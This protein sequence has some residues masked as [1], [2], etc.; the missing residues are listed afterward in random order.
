MQRNSR[1]RIGDIL[2]AAGAISEE[3]LK[4]GLEHAK[5]KGIQVGKAVTQLG[6][7]TQEEI[8]H[9]LSE[10]LD[11]PSIHLQTYHIDPAVKTLFEEKYARDK[12]ILPLFKI[13][14][15][16][17]VSM[18]D[19]LDVFT[20]DELSQ[21]T[22]L[23]I[24]PAVSTEEDIN[25]AMDMLYGSTGKI[26]EVVKSIEEAEGDKGISFEDQDILS[27]DTSVDEAPVIRLVNMIFTQAIREKAS[28]IHI[29]PEEDILRVRLRID[30]VLREL[31]TQPK[32]LQYAIISRIKIMAEL[33]IAERRLP[34]DGRF[35]LRVDN[36][37]VDIRVSTIPTVNGENIVMRILDKTNLIVRVEDLGFTQSAHEKFENAL[38][39]PNGIILVTGPTGSGK[40][41]TLYSAMHAINSLEKNMITIE[42]P[43]EYRLKI[44]R[45]SQVSTKIGMTFAMGLRA[46]LR[47]DPDI[48]MVGEIRDSETATVAVQAALTGHLVLSTLHTNDAPGAVTRLIDMGVEPFLVSSSLICIVA[49]RLVRRICNKCKTTYAAS[50]ALIKELHLTPGKE[51]QFSKGRGCRNCKETGYRGRIA[52][53]EVLNVDDTI[54][55]MIIERASLV[56]VRKAAVKNGMKTL[57]Q[58]GLLKAL[59][60]LTT[61]EEVVH[62]T[63]ESE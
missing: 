43:I 39:S 51:Y 58:D 29:E 12:K 57:R 18:V 59:K 6:F 61:V 50:D 7:T 35:Q 31:V 27:A 46:I 11:I 8:M 55:D 47:Q 5:D 10:Q 48:I 40:T 63:R 16:L 24:E 3:Q 62:T 25:A 21:K 56:Q 4:K 2:L 33:N 28:D 13:N 32:K 30:G 23:E 19:P 36:H 17:T 49:Q 15:S 38:D 42:D 52:I 44:I 14:N 45:Q 34:Q 54:R 37:D 53:F 26:D 1:L 22:N 60:G 41:T 9:A 20:I